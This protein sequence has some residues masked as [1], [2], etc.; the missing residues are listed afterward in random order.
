MRESEMIAK[1][2]SWF[3]EFY[4]GY[5]DQREDLKPSE[6]LDPNEFYHMIC[7]QYEFAPEYFNRSDEFMH[8]TLQEYNEF[9]TIEV[10]GDDNEVDPDDDS[11]DRG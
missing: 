10:Y 9:R 3:K 1:F 6:R 8:M 5:Y 7:M 2:G 4:D 11:D